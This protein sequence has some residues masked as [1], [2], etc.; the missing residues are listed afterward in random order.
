MEKDIIIPIDGPDR[1]DDSPFAGLGKSVL[2][3]PKV[4]IESGK[5][6]QKEIDEAMKRLPKD[7]SVIVIPHEVLSARKKILTNVTCEIN[8]DGT[9]RIVEHFDYPRIDAITLPSQ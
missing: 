1:P 3:I 5:I 6:T 7:E 2:V 8:E 4:A 9:L